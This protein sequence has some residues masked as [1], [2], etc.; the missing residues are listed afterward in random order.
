MSKIDKFIA[1][2]VEVE[3]GGE[4]FELTPFTLKDLPAL[5]KMDSDDIEERVKGLKVAVGLMLDQMFPEADEEEKDNIS[6]EYLEEISEAIQK[7]NNIEVDKAKAKMI[8]KAR[9]KQ[10]EKAN[11][12]K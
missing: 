2:P 7:I 10:Q 5:V 4:K 1:K 3:I 8:E 12:Q 9:K 6:L 11:E